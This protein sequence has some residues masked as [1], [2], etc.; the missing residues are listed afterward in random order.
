MSQWRYVAASVP[1]TSHIEAAQPCQDACEVKQ[2]VTPD[3]EEFL[4]LIA[5]DGAG[6]ALFSQEGSQIVCQ[7]L[8]D[9]LCRLI[10][11]GWTPDQITHRRAQVYLRYVS[12][13]I[14]R[15]ARERGLNKRD[16]AAT[17]LMAIIGDEYAIF[18]QLGDG[19][20]VI[21][22]AEGYRPIFWPQSGE[23]ANTTYFVTDKT[24]IHH[25]AFQTI[26]Q[27]VNEI[28]VLTDGIQGIALQYEIKS[29]HQP[30]FKPLFGSLRQAPVEALSSMNE[31]LAAFLNSGRVNERTA[32]DKT[33]I[34]ACRQSS[35]T[36]DDLDMNR[37]EDR[38]EDASGL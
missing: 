13:A 7:F 15:I 32:D 20:I 29:A 34:L 23:Y 38:Y 5:S 26:E 3:G 36:T 12:A 9:K 10:A 28:A 1:G 17:L 11:G 30:F 24:A 37:F 8:S 16:F 25:L 6:S 4:V 35:R 14:D 22:S 21:D 18:A 27:S 2:A 19:A 31:H 33:L